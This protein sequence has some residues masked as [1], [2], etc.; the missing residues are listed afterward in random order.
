MTVDLD[1]VPLDFTLPLDFRPAQ[2]LPASPQVA[3]SLH[4]RAAYM[5]LDARRQS[6]TAARPSAAPKIE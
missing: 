6:R 4:V 2:P 3:H 5:R 1:A